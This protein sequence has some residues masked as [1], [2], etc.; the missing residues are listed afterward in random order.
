[1]EEA[2]DKVLAVW[3]R[4]TAPS[5]KSVRAQLDED[6][7]AKCR[8]NNWDDFL[9]RVRTFTSLNWFAKPL[10]LDLLVCAQHGWINTGPDELHCQCCHE[11]L[12]C[13]IDSRLSQEGAHKVVNALR[14]RLTSYHLNTCPWRE[15]PSPA[16]FCHLRFWTIEEGSEAVLRSIELTCIEAVD[17]DESHLVELDQTFLEELFN[18]IGIVKEEQTKFCDTVVNK[19]IEASTKPNIASTTL[20]AMAVSG[21]KLKQHPDVSMI[22]QCDYCNRSV[23]ALQKSQEPEQ[24]STSKRMKPNSFHPLE[25]HRW[26]CPWQ[27]QVEEQPGWKLCAHA[28]KVPDIPSY[29][30]SADTCPIKYG[31]GTS[32][33][34][35]EF[36]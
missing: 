34:V 28:L 1:M 18:N 9:S 10:E 35:S 32:I 26:F 22:L 25:Q 7:T 24:E 8:P 14:E 5:K 31:D 13:F 23:V 27:R 4:A 21:W 33:G 12:H 36:A 30:K 15:N 17:V 16:S 11:K 20:V 19:A 3:K 29:K 6:N 2:V